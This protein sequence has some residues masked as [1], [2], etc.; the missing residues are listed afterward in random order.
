MKTIDKI[1]SDFQEKVKE[2]ELRLAETIGTVDVLRGKGVRVLSTSAAH[3]IPAPPIV[4]MTS[5]RVVDQAG[6][7]SKIVQ[8][9]YRVPAGS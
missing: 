5:S 3:S 8:A 9:R 2:I 1:R 4:S 6:S 7:H